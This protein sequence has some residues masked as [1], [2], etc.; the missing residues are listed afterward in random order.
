MR[1][2]LEHNC[3]N[4]FSTILPI[5]VEH[6]NYGGHMGNEVPLLLAHNARIQLLKQLG[7]SEIDFFGAG[8]IMRGSQVQY[9][10]E[11]KLG[12][13]V[14]CSVGLDEVGNS[15]A[16]ISYFLESVERKE[17]VAIVKTEILAF[18]Y[19]AKKVRRFPKKD[20]EAAI[21]KFT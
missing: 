9:L 19:Q 20:L 2:K 13:K 17:V 3:Q 15:N 21:V 12:E 16:T 1:I 14:I 4:I 5:G 7:Q 11:G 6:L 10:S 8:I 18:D